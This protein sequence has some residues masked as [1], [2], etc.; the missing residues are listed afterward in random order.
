MA[1]FSYVYFLQRPP[2]TATE[3]ENACYALDEKDGSRICE[4]LLSKADTGR[5]MFAINFMQKHTSADNLYPEGFI[6]AKGC[7]SSPEWARRCYAE[8]IMP[9]LIKRFSFPFFV[10]T[11]ISVPF[12]E[13]PTLD[14][15][16]EVVF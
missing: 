2:L 4:A 16:F 15:G 7:G 12:F 11:P 10:A 9:L 6:P 1:M 3:I 5:E 8:R 14:I 13:S